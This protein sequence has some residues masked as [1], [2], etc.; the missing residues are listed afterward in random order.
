MEEVVLKIE[1]V[2]KIYRLGEVGIKTLSEDVSSYINRLRGKNTIPYKIS[3]NN[4]DETGEGYVWALKDINLEIR[5]GEV[6]G[7]IG[8]NGA[9]KS[10]LL[11]LLSRVTAPSEGEIKIKGKLSSLL[12]VGTGFHPDLTGRE[13]I[14]LNGAILGMS[15]KEISK[16]IDDIV[17]F[18]G[19]RKYI[20][21]PVK[22]YS[23]GMKV[24]LGFAVAAHMEPDIL[25]VDEV[26][27]V[28]DAE[29]QHKCI[30]KMQDVAGEGRTVIFVS[31]NM[32]SIRNLCDKAI[33]LDNG[34]LIFEGSV[35]EGISK[36]LSLNTSNIDIGN[37]Y[38]NENLSTDT[39][40]IAKVEIKN[41]SKKNYIEYHEDIEFDITLSIHKMNRDAFLGLIVEDVNGNFITVSSTDE[42][43]EDPLFIKNT[44]NDEVA[45]S[46]VYP[47]SILKPGKYYIT[48]SFRE[49]S[50]VIYDKVEKAITFD[51]VDNTTF[52]GMKNRYR[53]NSIVSPKVQWKLL[54]YED[55]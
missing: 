52:R 21:T 16:K 43:E 37:H 25:V 44:Q 14:Y 34:G 8:K 36:Y 1:N 42:V 7:I 12:E 31:H 2:S 46:A 17:E 39:N 29:F 32:S 5:K 30:G 20:D 23:S 4:K 54:N 22:R 53:K 49:K 26:L 45:I 33:V 13:N 19:C 18:S 47:S 3:E 48:L 55:S 15:K 35:D 6:L 27:A 24:R 28:G 11:K 40:Q 38:I 51:I 50:N 9:G 41:L 10:T